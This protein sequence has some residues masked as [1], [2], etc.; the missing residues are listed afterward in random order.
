M[1]QFGLN[2]NSLPPHVEEACRTR[3][4]ELF[5]HHTNASHIVEP[6]SEGYL[7]RMMNSFVSKRRDGSTVGTV[8]FVSSGMEIEKILYCKDEGLCEYYLKNVL[9]GDSIVFSAIREVKGAK[10]GRNTKNRDDFRRPKV[11][12][13]RF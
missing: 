6:A 12:G 8:L 2:D 9:A 5:G 10:R 7:E 1:C 4:D 11:V 3:K 13:R